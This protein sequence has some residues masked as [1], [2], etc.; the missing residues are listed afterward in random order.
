MAHAIEIRDGV[1]SMMYAG[2]TPWHKLGQRVEKEVTAEAAI[3]L[4]NMDTELVLQPVFLRGKKVIDGIPVIGKEVTRRKAVVRKCDEHVMGVVGPNYHIIQNKDCFSF[5]DSIVG[6]GQAVYH[7]AGSL[8]NGEKIFITMK[9][10]EAIKIGPDEVE[11]YLLLCSS[12]DGTM[13]VHLKWTPVRVVCANTLSAA[14]G[15]WINGINRKIQARSDFHIKHT[16]NYKT[17]LAEAREALGLTQTYYDNLEKVCNQLLDK[18][19]TDSD[20]EEMVEKEILPITKDKNGTERVSGKRKNA[21][22]IVLQ[23]FHKG[24]GQ[25]KVMHTRWAAYNAVTEYVD[26][27]RK[28]SVREDKKEEDIR[29]QSLI[30]A[31]GAQMKQKAFRY[32]TEGININ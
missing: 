10:P 22:D 14:M 17:R 21:R 25:D 26:H 19:F 3:R 5:M 23:L 15:T 2:E 4:A 31:G 32:L 28:S 30:F 27:Y 7:T 20:M 1:A 11:K 8:F 16:S 6:E 24:Q 9:L 13:A 12:H 18:K 29:M